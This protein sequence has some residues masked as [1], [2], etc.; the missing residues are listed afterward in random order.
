MRSVPSDVLGDSGPNFVSARLTVRMPLIR[1]RHRLVIEHAPA[2]AHL[3]SAR[4]HLDTA[5]LAGDVPSILV[6]VAVEA[7]TARAPRLPAQQMGIEKAPELQAT[8]D[9]P[10]S[11][12]RT[13]CAIVSSEIRP[14]GGVGRGERASTGRPAERRAMRAR[15]RAVRVSRD[16]RNR[17]AN[18]V[19]LGG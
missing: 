19:D 14:V 10:P 3:P 16:E 15:R 2:L 11:A 7:V 5:A 12:W 4:A 18:M 9:R 8:H 17:F 6:T 13:S 1:K